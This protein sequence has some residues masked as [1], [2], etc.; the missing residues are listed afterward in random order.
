MQAKC[1][2]RLHSS[3]KQI[4]HLNWLAKMT[5]RSNIKFITTECDYTQEIV[6]HKYILIQL[7]FNSKKTWLTP[8]KCVLLSLVWWKR[9]WTAGYVEGPS[10]RTVPQK[11]SYCLLPM[12][13]KGLN[14]NLPLFEW[15]GWV[16]CISWILDG[17]G[18]GI[19]FVLI[20][21]SLKWLRASHVFIFLSIHYSLCWAIQCRVQVL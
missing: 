10:A 12:T 14:H 20:Q 6:F 9:S 4:G 5:S 13:T 16:L 21:K 8:V 15:L 17:A 11:T 3:S 19:C 7:L 18:K 2:I 1:P